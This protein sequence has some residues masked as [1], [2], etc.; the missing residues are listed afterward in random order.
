TRADVRE[1][2]GDVDARV[3]R[4]ALRVPGQ[5]GLPV[6]IERRES[7][8]TGRAVGED[9]RAAARVDLDLDGTAGTER[10]RRIGDGRSGAGQRQPQL[11]VLARH[12]RNRAV[13][14][15]CEAGLRVGLRL[16]ADRDPARRERHAVRA[17]RSVVGGG[18]RDCRGVALG[19]RPGGMV[20][21]DA[22]DARRVGRRARWASEPGPPSAQLTLRFSIGLLSA[23]V[24]LTQRFVVPPGSRIELTGGENAKLTCVALCGPAV[25]CTATWFVPPWVWTTRPRSP[26]ITVPSTVTRAAR[27]VG[28][29]P[30]SICTL[31]A[32]SS[33]LVVS[34]LVPP[35]WK[36]PPCTVRTYS[37]GSGN[38]IWPPLATPPGVC[39]GAVTLAWND[40]ETFSTDES[41]VPGKCVSVSTCVPRHR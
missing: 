3:D 9:E 11:R 32:P 12:D 2:E 24:T 34:R 8:D 35:P 38:S 18:C 6:R 25:S 28:S 30:R 10:L 21:V 27:V 19:H 17:V 29:A 7:E 26:T 33:P 16:D 5:Q 4:R 13:R 15:R 37:L 41:I 23:S 40:A 31:R 22:R 14:G 1:R 36:V 39:A 20:I